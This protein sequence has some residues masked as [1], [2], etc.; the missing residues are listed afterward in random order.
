M[1]TSIPHN[2]CGS[3]GLP[4]T[5]YSIKVL[6][7]AQELI[8]LKHENLCVYI[9]FC[10]GKHDRIFAVT[11][12]YLDSI[13]SL[14]N[15]PPA[16]LQSDWNKLCFKLTYNILCGLKYLNDFGIIHLGLEPRN[17]LLTSNKL[18]KLSN[19]GMHHMTDGG[20]LVLFPL[21][22][23]KYSS[24]EQIISTFFPDVGHNAVSSKSDVWSVAIILL[25]LIHK[26]LLWKDEPNAVIIANVLQMFKFTSSYSVLQHFSENFK[27]P[28]F[29][30]SPSEDFMGLR[31]VLENSL[32][33]EIK[34]RLK[35]ADFI[36]HSVFSRFSIPGNQA[37]GMHSLKSYSEINYDADVSPIEDLNCSELWYLWN[38]AGG[39]M[40][41]DVMKSVTTTSSI[42][43]APLL[44]SSVGDLTGLQPSP[45]TLFDTNVTLLSLETLQKR[46]TVNCDNLKFLYPLLEEEV[47]DE[48]VHEASKLPLLIRENDFGYQVYRIALF[49]R[50]LLAYPYL[51]DRLW[52]EARVDIPPFCRG[53]VWAGLLDVMGNIE[54]QYLNY[55]KET[56]VPADRQIA[57]DVPR[58]HQY[59]AVLSSPVAHQKLKR[60][61]KAWLMAHPNLTYW[62][63]LDSLCAVFVHLNFNDEP[64]AWVSLSKF[65]DK[66]LHKFFLKDN[67]DVIQE[68][69]AVFS[70]L[71]AFH[72]PLLACHLNEINFI[73][74]L[75]AIP[76][77]LTMFA[78]VFPLHKIVHLWDTLLLG[79]SSFPLCIGVAILQQ[80]RSQLLQSDFNECILLFS[81]L[82]E[83]D[84][85][86]VVQKSIQI[87]C[88]TPKSSTFRVHARKDVKMTR[89]SYSYYSEDYNCMPKNELSITAI[90]LQ[91][92]KNELCCRISGDDLIQLCELQGTNDSKTPAKSNKSAKPKIAVIDIRPTDEFARGSIPSSFNFPMRGNKSSSNFIQTLS[93]QKLIVVVGSQSNHEDN[94]GFA[95]E[96]L[97][98]GLKGVCVLH[99]GIDVLKP[100]GIL[101]VP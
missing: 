38:L 53:R 100:T 52:K 24:P 48:V 40:I 15:N 84:I 101:T 95:T 79:N 35:P 54:E 50:L 83:I 4:L 67:S 19:Y 12:Y 43:K 11:E 74:D 25:E 87:F 96:L 89:E 98:A 86:G 49:K 56:P 78:H 66:Y 60:V 62:Q 41:S 93:Q 26:T 8:A 7:L 94:K 2:E 73:P 36:N 51:R 99:G 59:N 65:I 33:P 92:L 21:G 22:N 90:P 29:H 39:D 76:W 37:N 10:C 28:E 72:D 16:L 97:K 70:H 42:T 81:D 46:L 75:Y 91:E 14:I 27:N 44:V 23:S 5:P 18:A 58:C 77:F 17:I 3:N 68:Y 88:H 1:K 32:S 9:D 13:E 85:D 34:H 20:K 31:F 6:G 71:I 45:E 30:I 61:L 69:L 80:L 64:L 63:G 82:P 57:V 47:G 55:D